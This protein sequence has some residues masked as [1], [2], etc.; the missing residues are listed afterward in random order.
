MNKEIPE[1]QLELNEKKVYTLFSKVFYNTN[2]NLNDN[3]LK[4]VVKVLDNIYTKNSYEH[5]ATHHNM[6]RNK[7]SQAS[8]RKNVLDDLPILKNLIINEFNIFKNDVLKYERNDFK[9]TTS[10][11]SK[12]IKGQSSEYHNHNNC[13]YSGIFYV[14]TDKNSGGISF[15]NFENTRFLLNPT[16]HNLYNCKEIV[17]NPVNNTL[18]FF[19]SEIHHKVL[20]NN[21][22]IVRYA[23]AFN[24]IPIGKIG[25]EDSDSFL[26]I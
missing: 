24:L 20:L 11:I 5:Y 17:I 10:W 18:I 21:S 13:M 1:K 19:P 26:E 14:Q 25:K 22:D 7:L 8:I 6:D 12:S 23:I 2:L 3:E 4:E 9:I 16:E 15:E